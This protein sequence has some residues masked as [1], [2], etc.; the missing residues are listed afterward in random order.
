ALY[1]SLVETLPL[2]VF[3]KDLQGRFTF[4]NLLFCRTVGKSRE[5]ILGK[6][7]YDFYPSHLAEKY[8]QDDNRVIQQRQVF[9][10]TEEHCKPD[11]QKLYVQVL[12]SPVYDAYGT[13]VGTQAIFWDVTDKVQA[14]QAMQ[15][16]KEA[17]ESANRAKSI[18]LANMS[19]EIRTP[20]NAIIGMT[21]LVLETDL[22]IE[23]RDYLELVQK[24]AHSLLAVINDILDF[25]KVEAGKLELD[26]APFSLRDQLGDTLNT[27]APPAYQK[28]LELAC[29]VPA[30]VPDDLV[31]DPVR[32]GQ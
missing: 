4:A 29:H 16:A 23:Q 5:E 21:D 3:R 10:L 28:G 13:V 11:G 1:H 25:S 26:S 2:N 31:G 15:Q 18:F 9:D 12:K 20:M 22:S 30:E 8:R 17:A 32:L 6:T 7:D 27:L 14:E 19:H 24:S